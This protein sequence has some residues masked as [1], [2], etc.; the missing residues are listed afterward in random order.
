MISHKS[1]FCRG[2]QLLLVGV[3]SLLAR[4]LSMAACD[5]CAMTKSWEVQ[6]ATV[7]VIYQEF[8][9]QV[10]FGDNLEPGSLDLAASFPD[11]FTT[12]LWF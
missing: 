12:V 8:Y 4:A 1:V 6:A 11:L 3:C 9:E 5:L 10:T 2:L 7:K